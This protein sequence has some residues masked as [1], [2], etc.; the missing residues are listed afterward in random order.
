[1]ALVEKTFKTQWEIKE[2][3]VCVQLMKKSLKLNVK[4]KKANQGLG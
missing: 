2:E 4:T 3:T 1:M